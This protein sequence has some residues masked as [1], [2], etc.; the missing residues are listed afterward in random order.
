MIVHVEHSAYSD[1]LP[2]HR[3]FIYLFGVLR[4]FQHCTGHITTDSW[5]GRGNQYIQFIRVLYCKLLT[6]SKQLPAFPLEA[7]PG[8]EPRPQRWEVRVLPL[9][10]RGPF[11]TEKKC[12]IALLAIRFIAKYIQSIVDL[13]NNAFLVIYW[14]VHKKQFQSKFYQ[15]LSIWASL[16]HIAPKSI[17]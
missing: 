13:S 7:V 10:H 6:N 4:R 11:C 5:K 15:S 12:C 14:K 3:E 8:T 9:C 2:L 17:F 1:N 16:G